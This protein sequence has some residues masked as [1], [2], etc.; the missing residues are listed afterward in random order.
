MRFLKPFGLF[1]ERPPKPVCKSCGWN[2]CRSCICAN[3]EC[4]EAQ[5]N[6]SPFDVPGIMEG[7]PVPKGGLL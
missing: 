4:P 1:L 5:M 2:V 7:Y 6:E 3:P